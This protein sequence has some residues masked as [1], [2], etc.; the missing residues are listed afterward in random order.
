M[1]NLRGIRECVCYSLMVGGLG[2]SPRAKRL[3][4]VSGTG[5]A[6]TAPKTATAR[7][8]RTLNCMVTTSG[9]GVG[10]KGRGNVYL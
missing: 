2:G 6:D 8:N 1:V 9:G 10:D 5:D 4:F 3:A 7:V